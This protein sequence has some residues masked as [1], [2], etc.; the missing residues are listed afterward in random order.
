MLPEAHERLATTSA[1]TF[2][3]G[4]SL[5]QQH[6][7]SI[8]GSVPLLPSFPWSPEA[9][10]YCHVHSQA[11]GHRDAPTW[12]SSL[13]GRG[14]AAGRH[15]APCCLSPFQA[16]CGLGP[17]PP[18]GEWWGHGCLSRELWACHREAP[19]LTGCPVSTATG[20][21]GAL[22]GVVTA[23]SVLTAPRA[24]ASSS[25]QITCIKT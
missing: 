14:G 20:R 21:W 18:T 7:C 11:R 16:F 6:L 1:I 10:P 24:L 23:L 25:Y 2:L 5:L 19:G 12:C 3:P 8:L 13:L 17:F 4:Q 15:A 22:A 9:P